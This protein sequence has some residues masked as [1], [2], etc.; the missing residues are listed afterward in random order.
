MAVSSDFIE[1]LPKAELHVHIE[2]ALEPELCFELAAR[3]GIG[4]DY[5]SV[6]ELCAAYQFSNLQEFF[7]IYYQG[8]KVLVEERDFYD[9]NLGVSGKSP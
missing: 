2:G 8:A 3:N 1:R 4:L 7:D 9:L 5:G 6:D